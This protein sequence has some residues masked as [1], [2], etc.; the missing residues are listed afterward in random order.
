MLYKSSLTLKMTTTN[1]SYSQFVITRDSNCMIIPIQPRV[2]DPG[3]CDTHGNPS[4][5]HMAITFSANANQP[6]RVWK[7]TTFRQLRPK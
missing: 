7:K 3:L 2:Y 6:A 5:D 1:R 4:G